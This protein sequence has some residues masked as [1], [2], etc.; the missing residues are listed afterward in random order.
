VSRGALEELLKRLC[1]SL[2]EMEEE[3]E[4]EWL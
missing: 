1:W 3:E 4:G 2:K